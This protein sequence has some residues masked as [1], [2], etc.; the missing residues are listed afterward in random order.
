MYNNQRLQWHPGPGSD[1]DVGD[2]FNIVN[3]GSIIDNFNFNLPV[4]DM[5]RDWFVDIGSNG[6]TL[7]VVPEP[8][9]LAVLLLASAG[10]LLMRWLGRR[11]GGPGR[12]TTMT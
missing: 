2:S 12:R 7:T 6:M 4:L 3:Y 5:G 1:P 10:T 9:S 8:S 11:T